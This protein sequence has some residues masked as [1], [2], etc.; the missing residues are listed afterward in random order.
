MTNENDPSGDV[1]GYCTD[2]GKKFSDKWMYNNS[3]IAQGKPAACNT[4][5]GV[6]AVMYD[7]RAHIDIASSQQKRGIHKIV[8]RR[9]ED[10]E[11]E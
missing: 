9:E 1:S 2:C 3:F 4:C 8:S 6:V 5:G 10:A 11:D 7:Q